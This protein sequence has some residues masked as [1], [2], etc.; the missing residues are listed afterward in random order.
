MAEGARVTSIDGLRDF[1]R[2]VERFG[3]NVAGALGEIE[4]SAQRTISWLSHDQLV[5]WQSQIRSRTEKIAAA[6]AALLRKQLSSMLDDPTCI[7][8]RR[9]LERAKQH[10]EEAQEKVKAVKRWIGTV[11]KEYTV[12]KG[13]A[14]PMADTHQR[15]V[16]RMA[17]RLTEMVRRLEE[18]AAI[19]VAKPNVAGPSTGADEGIQEGE[20]ADAAMESLI[21]TDAGTPSAGG[22]IGRPRGGAPAETDDA[23]ASLDID[24]LLRLR[25]LCPS[26]AARS[27]AAA[28]GEHVRGWSVSMAAIPGHAGAPKMEAAEEDALRAFEGPGPGEGDS[29]VLAPGALDGRDIFLARLAPA[30]PGD[31]GWFIGGVGW[32]ASGDAGAGLVRVPVKWL[33]ERRAWMG[34]LLGLPRG[35]LVAVIGGAVMGVLD[36]TDIRVVGGEGN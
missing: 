4:G 2:A 27:A 16:P 35:F 18:Y 3:E 31:S 19:S 12:Y 1:R 34:P 10:V 11:D 17:I 24:P 8:E 30:L 32:V 29:I 28:G 6:R 26:P 14:A 15:D 9:A 21:S 7:D 25:R 13:A 23:G 20:G 5:Y 33:Y 36:E 22:K